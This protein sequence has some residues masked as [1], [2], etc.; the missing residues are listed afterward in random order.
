MGWNKLL[1][2]VWNACIS[3]SV[4]TSTIGPEQ[5]WADITSL[6]M[7]WKLVN[8]WHVLAHCYRATCRDWFQ[9]S[10]KEGLTVFRDQAICFTKALQEIIM[11]FWLQTLFLVCVFYKSFVMLSIG[12]LFWHGKPSRKTYIWCAAPSYI[13]VS[14]GNTLWGKCLILL[15]LLHRDEGSILNNKLLLQ[16]G[17]PMA[18]PVRP[19]SYIKL[20]RLNCSF[21]YSY[22]YLYYV[23]CFLHVFYFCQTDGQFLHGYI[24]NF[25][26]VS[27]LENC[28]CTYHTLVLT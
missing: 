10:L 2:A 27:L 21:F 24:H 3:T 16:D 9:L 7:F 25:H 23:I 15:Y 11:S 13:T 12:I 1:H 19:H 17:G 26:F 20:C 8:L 22:A 5:V 14:S 18:H 4:C 6:L 28:I